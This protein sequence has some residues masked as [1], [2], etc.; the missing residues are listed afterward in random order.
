VQWAGFTFGRSQSFVDIFYLDPYQY[1]G[2]IS[3]RSTDANGT[4]LAAYTFDFGNGVTSTSFIEERRSAGL[5][6]SVANLSPEQHASGRRP[7]HQQL[8]RASVPGFRQRTARGIRPWGT[9]GAFGREPRCQRLLLCNAR[10][11]LPGWCGVGARSRAAATR[12][13]KLG[14]AAGGGGTI[15]LPMI[16]AGDQIGAQFVY[17]RGAAAYAANGHNS[18]GLF[19]GGNQVAVGWLTDG[20]FVT[21]SRS[22]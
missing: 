10:R 3:A 7:G 4:N 1:A 16:A 19:G 20:V 17:S 14:W 2:P 8:E 9:L 5:G 6:R 18:G 15:K 13:A 22:S 21:D 12:T 11:R